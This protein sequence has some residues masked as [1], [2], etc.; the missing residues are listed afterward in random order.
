MKKLKHLF[1]IS[2]ITAL[3]LSS[4]ELTR[5]I[6]ATSNPVGN[7]VGESKAIGIL[8]FPPFVSLG[9][10]GIQKAIKDGGITKISYVDYKIEYYIFFNRRTCIV[11]GE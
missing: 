5:P 8:Y 1:A 4:C 9:D 10:S 11:V 3:T 7:K 6:A 2:A